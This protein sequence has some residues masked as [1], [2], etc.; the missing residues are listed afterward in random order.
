MTPIQRPLGKTVVSIAPL[1][2]GTSVSIFDAFVDAA[3]LR[4]SPEQVTT[5]DAVSD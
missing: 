1:V 4:L 3:D 2:L 5:L